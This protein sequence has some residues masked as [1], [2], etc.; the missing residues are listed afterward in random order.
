[1]HM[2]WENPIPNMILHWT[3]KFKGL[4]DGGQGYELAPNVW[5]A[6][7]EATAASGATIPS[8]FAAR[9][10]NPE[11][12]RNLCTADMWSAWTLYL[13]PALLRERFRHG[14]H[15]RHFV[16]L[17]RLLSLC[18]KFELKRTE[19]EEIRLGFVKWVNL[20]EE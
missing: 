3:G 19:L 15:Y 17:V 11:T 16:L 7:A 8:S 5:Q 2:V 10:L 14:R 9:P 6:V 13:G 1:M 12:D 18:L 20:Y 4:D